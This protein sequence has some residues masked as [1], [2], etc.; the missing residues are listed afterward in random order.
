MFLSNGHKQNTSRCEDQ[1]NISIKEMVTMETIS[2]HPPLHQHLL[3]NPGHSAQGNTEKGAKRTSIQYSRRN[4]TKSWKISTF[5]RSFTSL[6]RPRAFSRQNFEGKYFLW[7]PFVCT[8]TVVL[9]Q[10]LQPSYPVS[11]GS[12]LP[13]LSGVKIVSLPPSRIWHTHF[14]CLF[15]LHCFFFFHS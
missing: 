2:K 9:S 7:L 14:K 5:L 3:R 12:F 1:V 4:H 10:V 15:P 11:F 8:Y 6:L 13:G